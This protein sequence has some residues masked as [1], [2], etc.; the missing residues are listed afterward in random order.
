MFY[1]CKKRKTM[2]K[3]LLTILCLTVSIFSQGQVAYSEDFDNVGGPTAGGAGTY[4]FPSGMLIRNVDNLT[5]AG[6]VSYVNE[7]W[8]RREDFATNVGDSAAF[9]TSWYSPAGTSND[10]MWT[11]PILVPANGTLSWNAVTYDASYR[12]GYEVRIMTVL[13]TGGTGVIGNQITNSTVLFSIAQENTTWTSRNV[14]LAAYAGQ[15]VYIGFRNTSTDKFLL[16][17]DDINVFACNFPVVSTNVSCSSTNDGSATVTDVFSSIAASS[18]TWAPSGGNAAVATNLSVG[19]YTCTITNVIGCAVTVTVNVS[20]SP[21]PTLTVTATNPLCNGGFGSLNTSVNG[22]TPGYTY[23]CSNGATT[24]AQSNLVAGT[25]NYTVTDASGCSATQSANITDPTTVSLSVSGNTSTCLGGTINL[26]ANGTGGTGAIT[27]T[28]MPGSV[29]T[30]TYSATPTTNSTY[31]LTASDA[32]GCLG[33]P[34]ITNVTVNPLPTVTAVTNNTLL[35][36]G[37]TATL[38][39]SGAATYTWS[40]SQTSMNIAVSPT[41]TETY[42]LTGTD[43]NGCTNT[44]TIQQAVSACTGIQTITNNQSFI[45]VYPNPNNGVFNLDVT[46]N[47][48]VIVTNTLGQVVLTQKFAAGKHVLNITHENNGVYF[49]K[50]VVNGEQ[51]TIKLVKD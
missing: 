12:E 50:V 16:L 15:T 21:S 46:T 9:S 1:F 14:S 10:F 7:A 40:T 41:V 20:V 49:V 23:L 43:A 27:Y 2:K 3:Q 31:T 6:S 45:S 25:Y 36:S 29:S 22:G 11:N 5:P 51:Q 42:T 38:T 24:T 17:I 47:A 8:E 4:T 26:S 32:N 28:W 34:V 13:P 44:T 30:N 39:A 35:C 18:F 37:Q 19:N 48:N 33:V